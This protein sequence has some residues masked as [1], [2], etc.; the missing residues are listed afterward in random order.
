MWIFRG[1]FPNFS[2]NFRNCLNKFIWKGANFYIKEEHFY[3]ATGEK[4]TDTNIGQLHKTEV[5]A[6]FSL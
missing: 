2:S 1:T 4:I 5:P 3:Q 6:K